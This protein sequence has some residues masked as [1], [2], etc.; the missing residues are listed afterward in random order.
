MQTCFTTTLAISY[1]ILF[2]TGLG[3]EL[4]KN[5]GQVTSFSK[6]ISLSHC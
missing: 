1:F 2:I 5:T 3:T 6:I 4:E